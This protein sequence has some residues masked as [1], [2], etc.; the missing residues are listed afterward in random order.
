MSYAQDLGGYFRVPS[1]NR[2]LNYGKYFNEGQESMSREE[3]FNSH[4]V[5]LLSLDAM[6]DLLKRLDYSIQIDIH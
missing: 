5:P 3:D 6:C 4:N 2:D 1:D